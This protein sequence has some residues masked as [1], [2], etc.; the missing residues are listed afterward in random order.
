[1]AFVTRQSNGRRCDREPYHRIIEY[2]EEYDVVVLSL[3]D[4]ARFLAEWSNWV[5]ANT[6]DQE[7]EE[8]AA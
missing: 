6:T 2:K 3:E 5:Q 4:L 8:V 7:I 1:V